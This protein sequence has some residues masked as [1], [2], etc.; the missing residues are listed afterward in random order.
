MIA[1][2]KAGVLNLQFQGGMRGRFAKAASYN[3]ADAIFRHS[4]YV[5]TTRGKWQ[6]VSQNVQ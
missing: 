6:P 5:V 3:K 4:G 1:M 2:E